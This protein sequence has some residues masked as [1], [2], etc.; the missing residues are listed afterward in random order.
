VLAALVQSHADADPRCGRVPNLAELVRGQT[1]VR[2]PGIVLPRER[3]HEKRTRVPGISALLL[4]PRN[5]LGQFIVDRE[6]ARLPRLRAADAG[7]RVR[8]LHGPAHEESR[9]A[10][11]LLDVAQFEGA[12]LARTDAVARSQK[13]AAELVGNLGQHQRLRAREM[14]V[15]V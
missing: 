5:P 8:A 11:A 13:G 10:V 2:I 15:G 14:I 7:A 3:V 9:H 6:P 12:D 1:S 4:P